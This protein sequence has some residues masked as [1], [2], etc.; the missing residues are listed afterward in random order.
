MDSKSY[1]ISGGTSQNR[2]A[3]VLKFISTYNPEICELTQRPDF[4]ILETETT[5]GIDA[6]RE[7]QKKISLKAWGEF[8]K[9]S[10]IK[11]AHNLTIEAQNAFLKTLE[12]P[13]AQTVI[14]LETPQRDLLLPTILS[15][16]L[17]I[18]LNGGVEQDIFAENLQEKA[19]EDFI[20]LLEAKISQKIEFAGELAKEKSSQTWLTLQTF[21]WRDL[22]LANLG[23]TKF[24]FT[25]I[26]ENDSLVRL[27][28]LNMLSIKN[29][30]Y[31][32]EETKKLLSANINERLAIENLLLDMPK[33]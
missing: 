15:R 32:I 4:F 22:L 5:I 24:F 2:Q 12:E 19:F 31:N 10:L 9:I 23:C 28:K 18:N 20:F 21:L 17:Q 3:H 16:C 11:D 30:L 33:V 6:V 14:I 1:L 13:P 7:L 29:Y 8:P 26:L 27:K 25:K